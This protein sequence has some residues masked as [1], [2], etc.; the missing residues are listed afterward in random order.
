MAAL[1]KFREKCRSKTLFPT[2]GGS[3]LRTEQAIVKDRT[4]YHRKY[5]TVMGEPS[6][7]ETPRER[8]EPEEKTSLVA[9]IVPSVL[10]CDLFVRFW[11]FESCVKCFDVLL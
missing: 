9:S 3:G 1:L 2:S 4:S 10:C 11:L 6:Y 7:L 8:T 5:M